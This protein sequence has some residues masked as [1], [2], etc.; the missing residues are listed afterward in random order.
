MFS[1][2][3]YKILDFVLKTSG[4]LNMTPIRLDRKSNK[5]IYDSSIKTQLKI[6]GNSTLCSL[7][8]IGLL[9]QNI[10]AYKERNIDKLNLGLCFVFGSSILITLLSASVLFSKDLC[11]V[12]NGVITIFEYLHSKSKIRI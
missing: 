2:Y 6:F 11:Q 1:K 5:I 12:I 3:F 7:W 8:F 9:C 10:V 4:F